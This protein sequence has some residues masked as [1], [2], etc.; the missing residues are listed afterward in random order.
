MEAAEFRCAVRQ[1][2]L[3]TSAIIPPMFLGMTEPD[4][5]SDHDESGLPPPMEE[6]SGDPFPSTHWSW[7]EEVRSGGLAS[8]AA[9]DRLCRI[10]WQPLFGYARRR[11]LSSED[12]QDAVQRFFAAFLRREGFERADQDK[13]RLR[14]YLLGCL[15]NSLA[16]DFRGKRKELVNP[17]AANFHEPVTQEDPE[18]LY[19]LVCARDLLNRALLRLRDGVPEKEWSVL[20]PLVG[21][22][23]SEP[24]EGLAAAAALG[25]ADNTVR[26]KLS[27]MRER[28]RA[29]L[30]EEV[31]ATLENPTREEVLEELRYLLGLFQQDGR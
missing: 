13:G 15:K 14:A 16:D 12:A 4:D 8:D 31:E 26:S 24:G 29:L 22:G 27:R 18:R 2:F 17:T 11:G 1:F 21:E 19:D 10:Y 23:R 5:S 28:Y 9:R 6:R 3:L 7:V 30:I 20:G 25:I